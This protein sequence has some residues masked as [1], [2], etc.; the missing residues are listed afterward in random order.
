MGVIVNFR[1]P[2]W[3]YGIDALIQFFGAF[4]AIILAIYGFKAYWV[5]RERKYL[6]FGSAFALLGLDLIIYA[7]LIPAGYIYY[8]FYPGV[9]LGVLLDAVRFLHF[10][11]VAATLL[12]YT[13]L[14]SVYAKLNRRVIIALLGSLVLVIAGFVYRYQSITGF[15]LVSV[16]L[17]GFIMIYTG[18]NW[19]SRKTASAGAVF[20]AFMLMALGHVAFIGSSISDRAFMIGH[21]LQLV[22]YISLLYGLFIMLKKNAKKNTTPEQL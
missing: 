9:Y 11:F 15:N 2:E 5:S 13:L 1:G 14:I 12:A 6:L 17:L 22:G 3:F 20:L 10:I 8:S 16:M 19:I 4:I 18:R 21:L 7:I